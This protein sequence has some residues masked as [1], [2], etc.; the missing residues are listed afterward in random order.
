MSTTAPASPTS[1][2]ASLHAVGV[3]SAPVVYCAP[4]TPLA[5]VAALMAEQ[6]IH[7]L[8][9]GGLT[10]DRVTGLR[11]V[12]GIVSDVD[13]AVAALAGRDDLVASDIAAGEIVT[14]H[15]DDAL[16]IVAR[17]MLEHE[18]GHVIVVVDGEPVGVISTLDIA[19]AVASR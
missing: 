16:D 1:R 19:G 11:M 14:V 17:R 3:M 8:A 2:L 5:D 15:P 12:W 10:R 4:D 6:R 13:V 7:C 9:T 18:T